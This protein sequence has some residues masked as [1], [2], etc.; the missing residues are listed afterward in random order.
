MSADAVTLGALLLA[1]GAAA[2]AVDLR[3]RVIPNGLTGAGALGALAL[4]LLLDPAGQPGRLAA[5]AA[6]GGLLLAA[7]LWRPDGMGMGDAKLAAVIGLCLGGGA[8]VALAVA[9]AAGGLYGVGVLAARGLRAARA[10]TMPFAPC[11]WLGS[12][13][14]VAVTLA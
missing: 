7:A 11:L 13:A 6:A 9:F 10:A 5:G 1:V 14:G 12:A 2:T 3:R 8:A 4:G